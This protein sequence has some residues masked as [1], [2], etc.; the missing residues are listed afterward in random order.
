[1][2]EL[3]YSPVA[4]REMACPH[5]GAQFVINPS[6]LSSFVGSAAQRNRD[7]ILDVFRQLFPPSGNALELASGSGVHINY[8]APHFPHIRFQPSDYNKEVFGA[9]RKMQAESAN[10]NVWDPIHIDLAKEESWPD[11]TGLRYDVIFAINLLHVAPIA[12]AE[13]VAQIAARV[14]KETGLL[15]IYGPFKVDGKYTA[16]SNEAFDQELRAANVSGWELKDVGEIEKV[17]NAQG[18]VLNQ[19]L[20]LPANNFMLVFGKP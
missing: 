10:A 19:Q 16:P 5:I 9:I 12:V 14:L 15:A 13:G 18:I 20:A 3:I 1:M 6:P 8:F 4:R 11:A 17:A 7:P 2:S